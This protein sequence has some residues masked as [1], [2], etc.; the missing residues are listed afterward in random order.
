[1]TEKTPLVTIGIPVYQAEKYLAETLDSVLAQTYTRLEIIISDNASTDRTPAICAAYAARDKR[2]RYLRHPLNMGAAYNF[3]CQVE[4]ARGKY[5]KWTA[6]DDPLAPTLVE[7]CVTVLESCPEAIMSYGRTILIDGNGGLIE[8]HQDNFDLRAPRP[9]VRLRQALVSSAWCH[10]VFGLIRTTVLKRTGKIGNYA[11]SDKVLLYELAINGQCHELPE[12]LAYRRLHQQNSTSVNRTDEEMAY[13][14][15]PHNRRRL[16]TPRWRRLKETGKAI[17][18]APLTPADKLACYKELGRF[19]FAPGR[20]AGA[21][22]EI[23]Q[24]V[25]AV[26]HPFSRA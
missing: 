17:Q 3:N 26:T 16:L 4:M 11:S 13:W 14:F 19:Y 6:Y 24:V 23:R 5:F 10:P 15:D 8:Y 22:K 12:H 2:I 9:A 20:A 21:V 1:M 25:R 18:R 7:K